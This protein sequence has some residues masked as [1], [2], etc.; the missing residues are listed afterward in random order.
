M[1]GSGTERHTY[2]HRERMLPNQLPKPTLESV[3]A[4]HG[5]FCVGAACLN[6]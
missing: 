1:S 2:S 3:V 6:R 4:L 5:S